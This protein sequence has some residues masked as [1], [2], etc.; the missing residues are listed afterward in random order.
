MCLNDP[1]ISGQHAEVIGGRGG[2]RVNDLGSTNGTYVNDKKITGHDLV[3]NDTVR[4][5]RTNFKFKSMN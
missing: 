2:F 1:S 5:G 3:D 4:L